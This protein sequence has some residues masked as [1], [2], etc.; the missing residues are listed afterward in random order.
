MTDGEPVL[1]KL[2]RDQAF[3][4][5][6]WLYEVLMQSD[7]L[8]AIVRDRAVWSGIYV[9]S[10]TLETTLPDVFMPDYGPREALPELRS[11]RHGHQPQGHGRG[12]HDPERDPHVVEALPGSTPS[13]PTR[14]H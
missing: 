10:G 1:I 7:K 2:T 9:I 6:D 8:E 14:S 11:A 4:L 12:P 5:S 3:V 13:A